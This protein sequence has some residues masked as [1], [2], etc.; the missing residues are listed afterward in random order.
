MLIR[1]FFFIYIFIDTNEEKEKKVLN[2]DIQKQ[3]ELDT[4][5]NTTQNKLNELK[6]AY[7]LMDTFKEV[8]RAVAIGF[9]VL[10]FLLLIFN[11]LVNICMKYKK[12]KNNNNRKAAPIESP[13][14]DCKIDSQI[15]PTI[16]VS[17][18]LQANAKAQISSV[19]NK[20]KSSL[21]EKKKITIQNLKET[22][23]IAVKPFK[24]LYK[25]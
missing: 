4:I 16:E 12:K 24:S 19:D 23:K 13:V 25:K 6:E 2:F 15:K 3:V 1:S 10:F 18:K 20:D 22:R 5:S 11:E 7:K 8:A 17:V 21:E 14:K 9:I